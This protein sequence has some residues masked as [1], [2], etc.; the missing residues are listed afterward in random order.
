MILVLEFEQV[1]LDFRL[2]KSYL[3][4]WVN[5]ACLWGNKFPLNYDC[6]P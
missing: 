4:L 6:Q 5:L 1:F 3:R 2:A